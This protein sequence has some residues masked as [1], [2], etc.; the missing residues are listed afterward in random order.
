M[1]SSASLWSLSP[2]PPPPPRPEGVSDRE[3][4]RVGVSGVS[5]AWPAGGG[6][7]EVRRVNGHS[8]C[9]MV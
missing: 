4:G 5:G 8:P 1:S 9:S 2:F 6:K 7:K 3:S